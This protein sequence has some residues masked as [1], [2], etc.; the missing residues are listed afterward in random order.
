MRPLILAKCHE[1]ELQG[2]AMEGK[3]LLEFRKKFI[4]LGV[5]QN[6]I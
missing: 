4:I 1:Q 6:F 5:P 3:N 2:F